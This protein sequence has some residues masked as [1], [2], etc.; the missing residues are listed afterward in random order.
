M[1][2]SLEAIYLCDSAIEPLGDAH[3]ILAGLDIPYV[4]DML[5][6][7]IQIVQEVIGDVTVKGRPYE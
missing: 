2:P 3:R 7:A 6:D 1:S 5:F 4:A